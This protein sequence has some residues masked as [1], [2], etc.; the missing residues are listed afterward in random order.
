MAVGVFLRQAAIGGLRGGKCLR[1]SDPGLQS[2][3]DA[4]EG[5][6][7]LV[8]II[9]LAEQTHRGDGDVKI[10]LEKIIRAMVALRRNTNNG[11]WVFIY[12]HGSPDDLRITGESRLPIFVA[13]NDQRIFAGD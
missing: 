11:E 4:Q 12:L 3:Q 7:T 6:P 10:W 1:R 8:E 2:A 9:A 13:E 5:G